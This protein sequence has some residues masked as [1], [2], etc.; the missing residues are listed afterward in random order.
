MIR[1]LEITKKEVAEQ[2]LAVQIPAYTVEAEIIEFHG[3]PQLSES[4]DSLSKSDENFY[5]YFS[6][7]ELIGVISYT[8]DIEIIDIHRL[9]VLPSFFRRG[10]AR[11][12]LDFIE[13]LEKD[14][15]IFLVS[16]GKKNIPAKNLYLSNGYKQ[17]YDKEVAPGIALSYF[18]KKKA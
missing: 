12:L 2:V 15:N 5:G 11:K 4:I 18:K 7:G 14:A 6:N 10:I 13:A 16:T 17:I 3:I 8:V 1:E 9:V